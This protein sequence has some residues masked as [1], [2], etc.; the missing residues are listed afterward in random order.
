[1]AT[2]YEIL[3]EQNEVVNTIIAEQWFV[4]EFYPGRYREYIEPEPI[5]PDEPEDDTENQ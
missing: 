2:Y 3:N 5:E 1:M 4:D